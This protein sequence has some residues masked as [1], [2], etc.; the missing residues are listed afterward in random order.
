MNAEL[1][2]LGKRKPSKV[3]ESSAKRR[4]RGNKSTTMLSA[5]IRSIHTHGVARAEVEVGPDPSLHQ[6]HL[7][8]KKGGKIVK[9]GGVKQGGSSITPTTANCCTISLRSARLEAPPT[10]AGVGQRMIDKVKKLLKHLGVPDRPIPTYTVCNEYDKL[11]QDAIKLFSLQNRLRELEGD[12][13]KAT[14]NKAAKT[15]E[16]S[17]AVRAVIQT[18]EELKQAAAKKKTAKKAG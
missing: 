7:K 1:K 14:G 6:E 11:R 2:S 3:D 4:I 13:E 10:V 5:H 17:A 15:F 18:E 9:K 8:K 16:H 12:V